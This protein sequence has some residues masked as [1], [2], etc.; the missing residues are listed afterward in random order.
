VNSANIPQLKCDVVVCWAIVLRTK[1]KVAQRLGFRLKT[2]IQLRIAAQTRMQMMD[3]CT[4]AAVAARQNGIAMI[5]N[6]IG[7]SNALFQES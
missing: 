5:K 7:I 4:L 1:F 3:Q 6:S 2:E